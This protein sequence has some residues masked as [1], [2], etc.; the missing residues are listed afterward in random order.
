MAPLNATRVSRRAFLG[1]LGTVAIAAALPPAVAEPEFSAKGD[2]GPTRDLVVLIGGPRDGELWT[3]RSDQREVW[4]PVRRPMPSMAV[5]GGEPTPT[6]LDTVRYV[7]CG[8]IGSKRAF[9]LDL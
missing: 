1:V 6:P 4:F 2:Q 7:W 5:W 9:L 8:N 3:I